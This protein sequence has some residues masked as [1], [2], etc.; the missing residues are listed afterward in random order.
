MELPPV[1]AVVLGGRDEVVGSAGACPPEVVSDHGFMPYGWWYYYSARPSDAGDG[2]YY[3]LLRQAPLIAV[4]A[5]APPSVVQ[6]PWRFG[7]GGSPLAA[8]VVLGGGG[9]GASVPS[10]EGKQEH[11]DVVS[12]MNKVPRPG[13]V[14]S[15]STTRVGEATTAPSSGLSVGE[16]N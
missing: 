10:D 14:T 13:D 7:E 8:V 9:G 3:I 12:E 5:A 1:M 15:I 11:G 2:L 6:Q 16:E 4:T